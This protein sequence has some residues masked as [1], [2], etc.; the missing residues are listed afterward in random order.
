MG[1]L[2]EGMAAM[3]RM[4]SYTM[5]QEKAGWEREDRQKANAFGEKLAAGDV[6][7]ADPWLVNYAREDPISAGGYYH[8]LQ[9]EKAKHEQALE[10]ARIKASKT[11]MTNIEKLLAHEKRLVESGDPDNQ[12]EAV[13]DV[14]EKARNATPL[15][16]IAA[17]DE[18]RHVLSVG[19]RYEL[20]DTLRIDRKTAQRVREYFDVQGRTNTGFQRLI[21]MGTAAISTFFGR[22]LNDQELALQQA[23]GQVQGL[24]GAIREEVVGGG[25]MTE[26]DFK[27]VLA[28]A[29]GDV[30]VFQNPQRLQAAL[31]FIYKDVMEEVTVGEERVNI[32]RGLVGLDPIAPHNLPATLG[33]PAPDELTPA[34]EDADVDDLEWP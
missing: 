29:G 20:E 16:S 4:A 33:P 11:G 32:Q 1:G 10:V 17:R 19:P 28:Y 34:E 18:K 15:V 5:A 31:E 14:I 23:Q 27:R 2:N 12:L 26:Q 30:T 7:G 8:K 9:M 24:A 22:R 3:M 13:R 21:D 6:E 25:V